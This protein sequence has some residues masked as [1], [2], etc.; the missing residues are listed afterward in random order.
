MKLL[1]FFQLMAQMTARG[2]AILPELETLK[3]RSASQTLS[4]LKAIDEALLDFYFQ[5]W[6]A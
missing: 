1:P 3:A 5:Q 4:E 6:Y 2:A